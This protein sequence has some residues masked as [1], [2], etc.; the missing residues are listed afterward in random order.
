MVNVESQATLPDSLPSLPSL[1]LLQSLWQ[2]IKQILRIDVSTVSATNPHKQGL[3][4]SAEIQPTGIRG[5]KLRK[6][7]DQVLQSFCLGGQAYC[8]EEGP[9]HVEAGPTHYLSVQTSESQMGVGRGKQHHT[10][11]LRSLAHLL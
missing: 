1:I 8:A 6:D 3:L 11:L 4:C 9:M 2:Q 5:T 7:G 10:Q